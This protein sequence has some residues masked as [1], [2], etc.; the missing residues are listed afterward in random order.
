MTLAL[1]DAGTGRLLRTLSLA[2]PTTAPVLASELSL[3]PE[4]LGRLLE[5]AM[6]LGVVQCDRGRYRADPIAIAALVQ[7]NR[8]L[9]LGAVA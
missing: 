4:Q 8:V 5:R 7:Y 3:E 1:A 9:L 2:G 6:D